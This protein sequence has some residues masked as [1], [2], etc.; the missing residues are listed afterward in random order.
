M[1]RGVCANA[2]AKAA[3]LE[4]INARRVI[5]C[6]LAESISMHRIL[7]YRL[8][9]IYPPFFSVYR[10]FDVRG[11]R[12]FRESVRRV[13]RLPPAGAIPLNALIVSLLLSKTRGE[14]YK[15]C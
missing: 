5:I 9:G 2:G 10:V 1:L 8:G 11:S 6:T 13:F 7:T 3:R 14:Q 4:P 15:Y 12:T